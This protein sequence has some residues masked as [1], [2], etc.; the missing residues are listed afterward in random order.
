MWEEMNESEQQKTLKSLYPLLNKYGRM[1][2]KDAKKGGK[3]TGLETKHGNCTK[4]IFGPLHN[5]CGP[6]PDPNNCVFFSFGINDDPT[7]D[8]EI[9]DTWGCRGFAGDPTVTHPSKLHPRVTFHN[10]AAMLVEDNDERKRD[11]GG[12]SQWW[13]TS[14]P[15]LRK[16]LKVDYVD[17]IKVRQGMI[18]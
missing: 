16:F 12:S 15:Q 17:I 11:K 10:F 5:L 14:M 2:T 1:L 18:I 6:A 9:A 3:Y 13:Y 7:F 8:I 4:A